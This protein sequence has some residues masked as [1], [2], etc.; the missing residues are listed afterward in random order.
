MSGVVLPYILGLLVLFLYNPVIYMFIQWIVFGSIAVVFIRMVGIAL[1]S[2]SIETRDMIGPEQSDPVLSTPVT[3]A[4][5]FI[6]VTI[7]NLMKGQALLQ[8]IISFVAGIVAFYACSFVIGWLL[9]LT[10]F[11]GWRIPVEIALFMPILAILQL[12]T[13]IM[14]LLLITFASA[15]WST[16]ADSFVAISITCAHVL[17]IALVATGIGIIAI[18]SEEMSE[19]E[20]TLRI[21][22]ITLWLGLNILLAGISGLKG[23]A[24]RRRPGRY[25]L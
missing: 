9:S 25:Y 2:T 12:L 17:I 18:P 10:P 8:L 23:F 4:E 24:V 15:L 7:G 19:I 11:V 16:I 1:I 6:G 13:V 14:L 5:L 20:I 21:A 22:G 3:N